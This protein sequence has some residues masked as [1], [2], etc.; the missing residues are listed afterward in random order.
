MDT[1]YWLR[2]PINSTL[3]A[4]FNCEGK[5]NRHVVSQSFGRGANAGVVQR[6]GKINHSGSSIVYSFKK[7]SI[8]L[9]N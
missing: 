9:N 3:Y 6:A 8:K 4:R 7:N 5:T 2:I 1:I